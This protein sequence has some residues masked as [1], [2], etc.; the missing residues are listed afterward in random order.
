MSLLWLITPLRDD[1]L[2]FGAISFRDQI[3]ALK[4]NNLKVLSQ[5][6]ED[7]WIICFFVKSMPFG[8]PSIF[9][10]FTSFLPKFH[11]WDSWNHD[12]VSWDQILL[13]AIK[14]S[15]NQNLFLFILLCSIFVLIIKRW[16][17]NFSTFKD[18]KQSLKIWQIII[19]FWHWIFW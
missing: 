7:C 4:A 8:S 17:W 1:I 13:P 11:I 10:F 16:T 9:R 12:C 15:Y 3:S 6:N 5:K 18:S 19:R 2:H 14:I